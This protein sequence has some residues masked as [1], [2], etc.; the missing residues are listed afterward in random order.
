MTVEALGERCQPWAI[1]RSS[2]TCARPFT[3]RM[4][5]RRMVLTASSDARLA[6]N[7]DDVSQRARG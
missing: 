2:M 5:R 4:R 7:N 1:R 6:L 3:Q